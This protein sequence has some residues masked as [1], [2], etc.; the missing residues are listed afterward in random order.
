[1]S[2]ENLGTRE[3]EIV[4]VMNLVNYAKRSQAQ[5]AAAQHQ[6]GYH[7]LDLDGRI[8]EGQRKPRERLAPLPFDLAGASVLDVGCNQGGMLLAAREKGIRWG[9]GIDYDYR[10]VNAAT[11]IKAFKGLERINFYCLDVDREE[12]GFIR[13][14]LPEGRVDIVFLLSVCMWIERWR[15][16]IT[17]CSTLAPRMLFEANGSE[18]QQVDQEAHLRTTYSRVEMLRDRSYDDPGQPNRSLFYCQI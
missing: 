3:A 5:Y 16:L 8:I 7:T 6:G 1:V 12:L 4:A 10:M 15:E 2:P 18:E 13:D 14:L 17:F 11:R 9:V